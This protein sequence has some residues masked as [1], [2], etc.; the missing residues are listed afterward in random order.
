MSQ[1]R[2]I[3]EIRELAA[4]FSLGALTQHE[5]RSFEAHILEGCPVCEREYNKFKH[6][7]AE[8]GFI[9]NETAAPD[10]IRERILAR[11]ESAA[12]EE[13]PEQ[14]PE[15]E[16]EKEEAA[17]ETPPAPAPRPV[18]T[19][20]PG[21]RLNLSPWI[22]AGVLAVAAALT[23]YAYHT[24]QVANDRLELE[25]DTIRSEKQNL[26]ISLEEQR[27]RQ[28]DLE[29]IISAV[30]KPETRIL[31]LAGYDP[32][33]AASGAILWDVQENKCLVFGFMPPVPSGKVYQLWYFTSSARIPSGMFRPDPDG[34][35][36]RWFPIP[37]SIASM[38]MII[39]LEPEGGSK[40]P[41]GPYYAIGR[42]D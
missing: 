33:P 34:R 29:Q 37:E 14:T 24:E 40:S 36:Y 38:S 35:V 41:S 31:H 30:S 27:G 3:E 9:V 28:G 23:F 11:I 25:L 32:I 16:P 15:S 2:P 4:L 26:E 10:H 1:E 39:T 20:L 17:P 7:T 13:V 5:A 21:K 42:K 22:L 6:I 18:L 8:I 12:P 19:Q